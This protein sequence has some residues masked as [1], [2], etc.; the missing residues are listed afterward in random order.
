MLKCSMSLSQLRVTHSVIIRTKYYGER[1]QSIVPH[2]EY[3]KEPFVLV[4]QGNHKLISVTSHSELNQYSNA[5]LL[6]KRSH[7]IGLPRWK[8][9]QHLPTKKKSYICDICLLYRCVVWL[10]YSFFILLVAIMINITW[11]TIIKARLISW[12]FVHLFS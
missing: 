5:P 12:Y 3:L 11:I 8:V 7:H 10:K 4:H 1:F 9:D 6:F 2:Q